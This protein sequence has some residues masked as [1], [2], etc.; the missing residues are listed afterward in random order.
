MN[1]WILE[2]EN[3]FAYKQDKFPRE[4]EVNEGLSKTLW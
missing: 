4:I 2:R 3:W 1:N